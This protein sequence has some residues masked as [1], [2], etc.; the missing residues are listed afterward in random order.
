MKWKTNKKSL[1][2]RKTTLGTQSHRKFTINNSFS[3]WIRN[4]NFLFSLKWYGFYLEW[5]HFL[6][7]AIFLDLAQLCEFEIQIGLN[8]CLFWNTRY[9]L[10]IER[11]FTHNFIMLK[12]MGKSSWLLIFRQIEILSSLNNILSRLNHNTMLLIKSYFNI[13]RN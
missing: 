12:S 5:N 13:F 2:W 11:S 1:Q 10:S 4:L 6:N 8:L 9:L 7:Q 3:N